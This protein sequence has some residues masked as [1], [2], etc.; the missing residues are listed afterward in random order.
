M[1]DLGASDD[2]ETSLTL[3]FPADAGNIR[4]FLHIQ[5]SAIYTSPVCPTTSAGLKIVESID[6]MYRQS[7]V[8]LAITMTYPAP[9]PGPRT[10]PISRALSY[11]LWYGEDRHRLASTFGHAY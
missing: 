2:Q 11:I 3:T 1:S 4:S 6:A 5:R 8:P 10:T 7:H 9:Q